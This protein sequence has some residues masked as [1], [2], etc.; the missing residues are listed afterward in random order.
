MAGA[1]HLHRSRFERSKEK[2]G[3]EPGNF[4]RQHF[5]IVVVGGN[6]EL[7]ILKIVGAPG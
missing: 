7:V 4:H 3:L 5:K 1:L 2:A 6:V